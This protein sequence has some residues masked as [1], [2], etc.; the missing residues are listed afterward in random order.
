M[1]SFQAEIVYVALQIYTPL[2]WNRT[3]GECDA[4]ELQV[5]SLAFTRKS[6]PFIT[7]MAKNWLL[8]QAIWRT[9]QTSNQRP[10]QQTHKM[11]SFTHHKLLQKH[12]NEFKDKILSMFFQYSNYILL[13]KAHWSKGL[14]TQWMLIHICAQVLKLVA[15][16]HG[17]NM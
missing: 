13:W 1:Q 3:S 17:W 8:S 14:F 7:N 2:K 6:E 12:F 11:I 16:L 15:K 4:I 5:K 9:I 10:C